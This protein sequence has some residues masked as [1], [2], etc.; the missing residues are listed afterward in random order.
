MKTV[1]KIEPTAKKTN[2]KGK[3]NDNMMR[4]LNSDTFAVQDSDSGLVLSSDEEDLKL[5]SIQDDY[6]I[7][8]V[9]GK[10]QYTFRLYLVQVTKDGYDVIFFKHHPETMKFIATSEESYVRQK[11][12]VRNLCK[13]LKHKLTRYKGMLSFPNDL[14]DLTNIQ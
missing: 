1:N 9:Y 4:Q 14:R 3:Y 5:S 6:C 2:E 12:L 8:K 10:S 11:D 7:V 13:P